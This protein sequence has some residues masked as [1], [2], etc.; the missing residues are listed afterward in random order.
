MNVFILYLNLVKFKRIDEKYFNRNLTIIYLNMNS[1]RNL[2][3]LYSYALLLYY[4]FD[5]S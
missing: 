1:L 4:N 2:E 3:I 5:S